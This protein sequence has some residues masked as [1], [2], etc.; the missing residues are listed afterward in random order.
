[1]PGTFGRFG[2]MNPPA[3]LSERPYSLAVDPFRLMG[4]LY[5]VGTAQ[6]SSHLI[7]IQAM[8][9]FCLMSRAFRICRF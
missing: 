1:M 6:Q 3:Y 7:D 4:N 2:N 8:A 9:L 5:F